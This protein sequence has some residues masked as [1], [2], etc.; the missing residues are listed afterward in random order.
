VSAHLILTSLLV[1]LSPSAEA[2]DADTGWLALELV[3]RS[4][5]V[6]R[7]PARADARVTLATDGPRVLVSV[8]TS[9]PT[10]LVLSTARP[11]WR[12][13]LAHR[14]DV[15]LGTIT[16]RADADPAATARLALEPRDASAQATARVQALA[17]VALTRGLTLAPAPHDGWHVCV[18]ADGARAVVST[19]PPTDKGC[20]EGGDEVAHAPDEATRAWSARVVA[21]LQAARARAAAPEPPSPAEPT[22]PT[23]AP[24]YTLG[25][26]AALGAGWR[27]ELDARAAATASLDHAG[28][29]GGALHVR[30]QRSASA[31]VSVDELGAHLGARW[32][33]PLTPTLAWRAGAHAGVWLHA[34]DAFGRQ[35]SRLDPSALLDASL[36]WRPVPLLTVEPTATALW[37]GRAVTHTADGETLWTRGGW[38]VGAELRVGVVWGL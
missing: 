18:S 24:R 8:D 32:T 36:T 20:P 21:T 35:G 34:Y 37:T 3:A 14:L 29:P 33:S 17:R 2:D 11:T 15:A 6:T 1:A 23:H 7:D 27:G 31:G 13:E 4:H 9:P 25:V 26:A 10:Q 5:A 30:T 12:L 28:G 38:E 19:S 22:P 16:P